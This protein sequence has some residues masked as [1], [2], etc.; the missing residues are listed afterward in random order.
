VR[1][2]VLDVTPQAYVS[3]RVHG[4]DRMWLESNCAA[5]LWIEV[6]H[7]LGLEPLAAMGF[8]LSAGF[9]GEQWRMFKFSME[10]VRRL[11][12]VDAYEV[13]LWRALP[14]HLS[15]QIALG[16]M[17][18]IDVDAWWLPDTAGLTYR[19]A[20]QKTT[21]AVQMIDAD[22]GRIGYF[23]NGGYY[24]L[25]GEDYE[26]L[27]ADEAVAVIPPYAEAIDLEHLRLDDDPR[28]LAIELAR[29]HLAR[30][31]GSNPVAEMR[32]RIE[33]DL[34]WLIEAGMD[35]FH[36]YAFGSIRQ[37]GSNAELAADY[38]LWLAGDTAESGTAE[39]DAG[40]SAAAEAFLTVS[41]KAKAL[42]FLLARALRGKQVSLS[43]AMSDMETAW[44]EAIDATAAQLHA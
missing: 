4:D 27:I 9:D 2:Q 42:E 37:C 20:H 26:R 7:A 5:D 18:T 38:V 21:V 25:D 15:D 39:G 28:P 33:D 29:E 14:V 24:E 34:P 23:H 32:K 19:T 8:L 22:A 31:P 6:L 17:I 43:D 16:R 10:D 35:T 3:H 1:V 13:N 30:R 12:G 36:R 41:K 44:E 40:T 11:Y